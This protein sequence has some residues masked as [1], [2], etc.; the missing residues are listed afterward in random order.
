MLTPETLM[1][2]KPRLRTDDQGVLEWARSLLGLQ[3][4]STQFELKAY[5]KDPK[6][7]GEG[8]A[9]C[10]GSLTSLD[11]YYFSRIEIDLVAPRKERIV[12]L[13]AD[14]IEIK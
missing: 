9:L 4:E 11:N 8:Y 13:D 6:F 12:I 7:Y 10:E 3:S 2:A 1:I 5:W 14:V